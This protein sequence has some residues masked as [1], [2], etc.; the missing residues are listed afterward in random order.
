VILVLNP[1]K[2][3]TEFFF[4][5]VFL[6]FENTRNNFLPWALL[7]LSEHFWKVLNNAALK[8]GGKIARH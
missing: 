2:I 8:A 6:D 3:I 1:S 5:S 4:V 7:L